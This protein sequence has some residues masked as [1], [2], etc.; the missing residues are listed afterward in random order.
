MTSLASHPRAAG[1]PSLAVVTEGWG[2]YANESNYYVPDLLIAEAA[3]LA[4]GGK[5][6]DPKGVRLAVEVVSPSN[7]G[8]DLL[9]KRIVYA[10]LGIHEY[11]IV[12][13]RHSLL[14]VLQLG[15]S[16]YL[17]AAVCKPGQRWSAST[18]FPLEV[19]PAEIF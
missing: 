10:D 7:P 11:W 14:I 15:E 2:V 12:D 9:L 13:G 8:N 4:S 19:D 17:E 5:G 18:P 6:I 3:Q 1:T 16:G